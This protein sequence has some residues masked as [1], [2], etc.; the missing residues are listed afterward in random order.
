MEATCG[1]ER[2]AL[3][4]L[5]DAGI[6]VAVVNPRQVRRFAEGINQSAKTDKLDAEVLKP[7]W[8]RSAGAGGAATTPRICW[9]VGEALSFWVALG[10]F[11]DRCVALAA[12]FQAT[13]RGSSAAGEPDLSRVD[14]E[15]SSG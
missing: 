13:A 5:Q 3:L 14:E 8:S 11:G 10:G 2:S 4:A 15:R 12:R 9:G 1:Y 6:E 7:G